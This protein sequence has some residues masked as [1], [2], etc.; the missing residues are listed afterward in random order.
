VSPHHAGEPQS[1]H[2]HGLMSASL[3]FDLHVLELRPH[4]LRLR[5]PPEPEAPGSRLPAH[6]REDEKPERLRFSEPLGGTRASGIAPEL[7]EPGLVG[8]QLR[9]ASSRCSNPATKSSAQLRASQRIV[10]RS[11]RYYWQ[12]VRERALA[13][14]S[15]VVSAL[16]CCGGRVSTRALEP[17]GRGLAKAQRDAHGTPTLPIRD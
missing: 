13:I 10:N 1:L 4:P 9:S 12:T 17:F 5:D 7:D 14:L 6:V 8:V 15:Q 16:R 3:R 11:P 2:R